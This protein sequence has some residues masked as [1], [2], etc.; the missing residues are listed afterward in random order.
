MRPI[1]AVTAVSLCLWYGILKGAVAVTDE[2]APSFL[3]N[4]KEQLHRTIQKAETHVRARLAYYR[5][6]WRI[7]A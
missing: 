6:K 2:M 4:A 7:P 1:V 5:T 3:P